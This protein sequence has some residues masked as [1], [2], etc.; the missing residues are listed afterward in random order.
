M[1]K[2]TEMTNI[3]YARSLYREELSLVNRVA[4][5]YIESLVGPN[6]PLWEQEKAYNQWCNSPYD[7][8]GWQRARLEMAGKIVILG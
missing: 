2:L 5:T 3:E 7:G 1:R 4:R 6:A 8:Y